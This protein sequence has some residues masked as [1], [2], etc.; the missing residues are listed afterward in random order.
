MHLHLLRRPS[1][2]TV[3]ATLAVALAAAIVIT[4]A[5][6][7]HTTPLAVNRVAYT[8]A[9]A[10]AIAN[11]PLPPL[12]CRTEARNS[13][14][15]FTNETWPGDPDWSVSGWGPGTLTMSRSVTVGNTFTATTTVSA[16]AVSVA[17]GFNAST[18]W[19]T[20]TS[21]TVNVPDGE[22][23]IIHAGYLSLVYQFDIVKVCSN[24]S[25]TRIGTGK[26]F[27]YNHVMYNTSR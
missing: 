10:T 1:W 19:T 16:N 26:A 21:Y 9:G 6:L 18:S 7:Q 14:F 23:R 25:V 24:G 20:G 12:P 22:Q 2:R 8:N 27:Q 5:V 3:G 17:V 13:H 15:V 4:L 11:A